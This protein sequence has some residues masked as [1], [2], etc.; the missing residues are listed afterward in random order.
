[1][2]ELDAEDRE[3]ERRKGESWGAYKAQHDGMYKTLCALETKM[4]GLREAFDKVYASKMTE[5]IVN[6]ALGVVLLAVL[7]ALVTLVV[8]K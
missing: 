1:M 2:A 5:T 8:K 3:H 6:T 4:D 7:G